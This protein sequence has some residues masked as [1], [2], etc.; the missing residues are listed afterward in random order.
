[1]TQ[2]GMDVFEVVF[3]KSNFRL[4]VKSRVFEH[5]FPVFERPF[6]VF[7]CPFPVFERPFQFS[8][9]LFFGK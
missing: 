2:L 6:P 9:N 1:M 4:T 5:P 3:H 8:N 7:E